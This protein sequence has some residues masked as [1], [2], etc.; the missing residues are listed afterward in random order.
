MNG[1]SCKFSLLVAIIIVA[2]NSTAKGQWAKPVYEFHFDGA[3][4]NAFNSIAGNVPLTFYDTNNGL[5]DLHSAPGEGVS[6]LFADQCMDN[7]SATGMGGNGIG[8]RAVIA[9]SPDSAQLFSSFTLQ[10]WFKAANPPTAAARLFDSGKYVAYTGS[11]PGNVWLQVNKL[12][13]YSGPYYAATNQWIFFAVSYDS[14]LTNDNVVFYVGT[15]GTAVKAATVATLQAGMVTN[16]GPIGIGNLSYDDF[17]PLQGE[18]D[19]VR[20]YGAPAGSA[21]AVPLQQ[22]EFLRQSDLAHVYAIPLNH[23]R[24][25]AQGFSFEIPGT[26]PNWNYT[27]M[28]STN[29]MDWQ[30]LTNLTGNGLP[31]VLLDTTHRFRNTFYR[32]MAN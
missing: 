21:G 11:Q 5:V 31:A 27:V 13:V 23:P 28:W 20:I 10:C 2:C 12:E 4:T 3:G 25:S 9:P 16:I 26:V 18:M 6:G 7:R 17:R 24:R 1:S 30:T 29:L 22:L 15:A 14:T 8:S 32:V 19:D